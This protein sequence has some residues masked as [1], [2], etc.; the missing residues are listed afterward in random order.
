MAVAA[1]SL[2]GGGGAA[3]VGDDGFQIADEQG[4]AFR[5]G[6]Q[7]KQLLFEI[8][9]E[10]QRAGEVE[11]EQQRVGVGEILFGAGD[12]QQLGMQLNRARSIFLGRRS[13]FVIDQENFGLEER[14]FLIDT[15][16]FEAFAALGDEVEAAVGILFY[17]G[18]DF[19]GASHFGQTL[20]DNAHHTEGAMLG[21]TLADHFLVAWF[22]DVQGQRSAGEQ[23]DIEREQRDEGVQ[24]VSGGERGLS[25][26]GALS[27]LY[28]SA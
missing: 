23:D 27:R 26:K 9:I 4:N 25:A 24:G 18:D 12:G 14:T 16:E 19:S 11:R 10:G 5:L 21:Q 15:H 20:L 2:A 17:D 1:G 28:P 3:K 13:R 8:Q 22:E 6:A 7:G